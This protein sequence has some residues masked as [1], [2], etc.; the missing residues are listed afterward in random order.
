MATMTRKSVKVTT[1]ENTDLKYFYVYEV[2]AVKP[3]ME[4]VTYQFSLN[5]KDA[6]DAKSFA[7]R[8]HKDLYIMVYVMRRTVWC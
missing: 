6:E 4:E 3:N 7:E 1:V 5:K 2:I 8:N